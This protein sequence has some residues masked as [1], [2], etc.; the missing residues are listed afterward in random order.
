MDKVNKQFIL[1]FLFCMQLRVERVNTNYT[2]LKRW[3]SNYWYELLSLKFI[4]SD[5]DFVIATITITD[6]NDNEPQLDSEFIN[7]TITNDNDDV[8]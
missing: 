8:S 6:V 3:A 7:M 4:I 5:Q 1:N 2:I